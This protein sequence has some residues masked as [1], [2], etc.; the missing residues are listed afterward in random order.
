MKP[1]KYLAFCCEKYYFKCKDQGFY[2]KC[3]PKIVRVESPVTV[4]YIDSMNN[5]WIFIPRDNWKL[6]VIEREV[7]SDN[8]SADVW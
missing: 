2:S 8:N 6:I 7:W 4:C 5:F 1:I 3:G